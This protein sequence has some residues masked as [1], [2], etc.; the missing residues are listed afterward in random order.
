LT[1]RSALAMSISAGVVV[2]LAVLA[3]RARIAGSSLDE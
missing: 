1:H 2:A 3:G